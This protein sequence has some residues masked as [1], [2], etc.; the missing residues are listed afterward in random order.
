[1]SDFS[2]ED[3]AAVYQRVLTDNI[4]GLNLE[5]ND[6]TRWHDKNIRGQTGE[7]GSSVISHSGVVV[8]HTVSLGDK[9]LDVKILS[10]ANVFRLLYQKRRYEVEDTPL[11]WNWQ[12][13]DFRMRIALE[14]MHRWVPSTRP[15]DVIA[16]MRY[17]MVTYYTL[18]DEGIQQDRETVFDL[19]QLERYRELQ[20]RENKNLS[21]E[22]GFGEFTDFAMFVRDFRGNQANYAGETGSRLLDENQTDQ[23]VLTVT[24][25]RKEKDRNLIEKIKD[26][27]VDKKKEL[28][29][30][31][32]KKN[33]KKIKIQKN[34]IQRNKVFM[35]K[36]II[37]EE[38][39]EIKDKTL[40]KQL[41]VYKKLYKIA[42]E[43]SNANNESLLQVYQGMEEVF[44]SLPKISTE[45]L[46]SLVVEEGKFEPMRVAD[47]IKKIARTVITQSGTPEYTK[48]KD[49]LKSKGFKEEEANKLLIGTAKPFL[50]ARYVRKVEPEKWQRLLNNPFVDFAELKIERRS[51]SAFND[52]SSKGLLHWSCLK[53]SYRVTEQVAEAMIDYLKHGK[54]IRS[55]ASVQQH[56][57]D[58]AFPEF[59]K[60]VRKAV[61]RKAKPA[62]TSNNK[63][64][65]RASPVEGSLQTNNAALIESF[66][67]SLQ[68]QPAQKNKSESAQKKNTT[69][70]S[71]ENDEEN[72]DAGTDAGDSME[73]EEDN[74]HRERLFE[75]VVREVQHRKQMKEMMGG[76]DDGGW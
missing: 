22:G 60:N 26:F 8:E 48:K 68:L 43:F 38:L 2:V 65:N 18:A 64:K 73:I 15:L 71:M 57:G 17:A 7:D 70:N 69:G 58:L 40:R 4:V 63:N 20:K 52:K 3:R 76:E 56:F 45:F 55:K 35:K 33:G 14:R 9:N 66:S 59:F 28:P 23:T 16:F 31:R 6:T 75:E 47:K 54:S 27:F 39:K 34:G 50:Q 49:E 72:D 46:Q 5:E 61:M 24:W 51:S 74:M 53:G 12:H 19:K 44:F 25:K 11:W 62:S 37:E 42:E 29:K 21:D 13:D 32:Y 30:R 10:I 36:G 41:K 1:M 67:R